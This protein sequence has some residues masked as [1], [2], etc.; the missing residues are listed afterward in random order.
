[1]EIKLICKSCN[2]EFDLDLDDVNFNWKVE[3]TIQRSMGIERTWVSD[4][5]VTCPLCDY[6]MELQ[7]IVYEYPYG[8]YNYS[9][10][11]CDGL[12][13]SENINLEEYIEFE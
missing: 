12:E 9:S 4:N 8:A 10:I 1:M 3:D 6:E 11:N 2:Q 5:I 13:I 7:F